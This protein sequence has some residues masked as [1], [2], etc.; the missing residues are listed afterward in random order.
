MLPGHT[1]TVNNH[2]SGTKSFYVL[3]YGI[4]EDLLEKI[5]NDISEIPYTIKFNETTASQV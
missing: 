5:K 4:A 1:A 2:C 3:H